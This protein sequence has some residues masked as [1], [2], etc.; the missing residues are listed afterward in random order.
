MLSAIIAVVFPI[1]D[2]G[3][4]NPSSDMEGIVY[5][6]LTNERTNLELF[7]YS[8]IKTPRIKPIIPATTIAVMEIFKCSRSKLRKKDFLSTNKFIISLIRYHLS[9]ALTGQFS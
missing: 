7:W 2:K 1:P 5:I 8:L 4:K 3:I 9:T 6:K